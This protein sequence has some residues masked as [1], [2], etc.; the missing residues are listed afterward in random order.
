[1]LRT[2]VTFVSF[3]INVHEKHILDGVAITSNRTPC[4]GGK[5]AKKMVKI[6]LIPGTTATLAAGKFLVAWAAGLRC[7]SKAVTEALY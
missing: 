3:I 4:P 5:A 6:I 1:M 7:R 2:E